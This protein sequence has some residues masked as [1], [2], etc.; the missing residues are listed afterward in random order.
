[1]NS[2]CACVA[3]KYLCL[4]N[5]INSTK[6]LSGLVPL[7]INPLSNTDFMDCIHPELFYRRVGEQGVKY[8]I[9]KIISLV[10][11]KIKKN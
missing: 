10:I 5:S 8:Y 2:G 7:N 11:K 3:T 6:V 4:G 1:M 9:K